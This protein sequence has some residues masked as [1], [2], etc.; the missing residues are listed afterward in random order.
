[1]YRWILTLCG[2]F[3]LGVVSPRSGLAG[4]NKEP[5][6]AKHQPTL[7]VQLGHSD[8]VTCLCLSRDNK[9]LITGSYDN[10]A[11]LWEV[12]TGTEIRAF[13]GHS[14]RVSCVS[15][16]HDGKWLVTGS[17]DNTARLWKVATG[18]E[19]R[20]FRGHSRDVSS[21]S[22]S[23]DGKWLVT[24]SWDKTARLWEV[25]TGK[26]VRAFKGHSGLVLS[27]SLSGDGKRLVTGGSD[28][29]A[30]L[31]DV[32][33]GK[34]VRGFEGHA[35]QVT[36]VCLSND[37]KWV[38]TGSEDKSA[39]LWEVATGKEIL[40]FDHSSEVRSVSMSADGTWL[41]TRDHTTANL[42]EVATRK[43]VRTFDSSLLSAVYLSADGKWLV[44]GTNDRSARLWEAA[45]GKEV[46]TFAG[47][48]ISVRSVTLSGDGKRLA[49]CVGDDTVCMWDAAAGNQVRAFRGHS[50]II[51][52]AALSHDGKW[53][54]T[55]SY[56]Q[57]AR[58]WEVA[59]AKEAQILKHPYWVFAV[60]LSGDGKWLVT[61]SYDNSARL[62]EAATGKEVRAF[63]G[64][65]DQVTS[66]C[67][68]RD[69]R[70]LVTGSQ[71]R[72]ARLW[73]VATG[74]EVRTFRGHA[75]KVTSVCLSGD[76]KSLLSASE[77][78]TARLWEVAT[79]KELRAFRDRSGFLRSVSLSGDGKWLVTSSYDKT[80]TLWN[81]TTGKE[82]RVF[83][84]HSAGISSVAIAPDGKQVLTGSEDCTTRFWDAAT[85][86]E[87]CRLVSF[88]NGTWAV[89]APDGRFDTND[90]DE[91]KGLHWLMPDD[92][93]TPLPVEIFQ[94]DYYEPRLLA[95]I[96]AGE[97]LE[98]IR[99]LATLNRVQPKIEIDKIEPQPGVPD[100]VMV[101]VTVTSQSRTLGK[102]DQKKTFH[103]GA[104]DLQLFRDGQ[105]VASFPDPDGAILLDPKTGSKTHRFEHVRLP[106]TAGRKE[107]EFSAY[108]FNGDRVKSLTVRVRHPLPVGLAA[109]PRTAY[110]VAIGINAFDDPRWDLRYAVPDARVLAQ[111]LERALVA[112]KQFKRV[113]VVPLVAD[114]RYEGGK[115]F[116]TDN[117]A[118]KATIQAVLRILAG[119]KADA[120]LLKHVPAAK[121][122]AAARPEDL[123]LISFSTHGHNGKDGRFHLLP[124]DM[125]KN[126][127]STDE[128]AHW[129]RDVDAGEMILIVDACHS[130]A[131]VDQKGFKPGP[132]GS[133]GLGQM[134]YS[135]RMRILAASQASDVA[136]EDARLGHGL[137]TFALLGDG[138][139]KGL[140]DFSP[141][142][143]RITVGEWLR[144]GVQR[145]PALVDDIAAGK[146]HAVSSQGRNL[147]LPR[148]KRG[149]TVI[150][151]D[152][153]RRKGL[154]QQPAL[155]DFT[156]GAYDVLLSQKA[157]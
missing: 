108:A 125:T 109:R 41:A 115:R 13:R 99:S 43:V 154:A 49:I 96:L 35:R 85:G 77:D 90:L 151:D 23:A 25:A 128:L 104:F 12:A 95:R 119:H 138:L 8:Y 150:D 92:P 105:L 106:R 152:V 132:M 2:L 126:T 102:A 110:V 149:L 51:T 129:L 93:F 52:C 124:S 63:R 120:G 30:C 60:A 10:T 157:R 9:W 37:D 15:L 59:R 75:D 62:W 47:H 117:S 101:T 141:K 156:R 134:A 40:V 6:A 53:L 27:V 145:V 72:T 100:K 130:A 1:M 32:A 5:V 45:T 70:W 48:A 54:A 86:Q 21:V 68:S 94:R 114:A 140:A 3:L 123:V 74:K 36:S 137:L 42:W 82:V 61:N 58:L 88:Q 83:R 39:R 71:D 133:R 116:I 97:K 4:D 122:L 19:I 139:K 33:T 148:G 143:N 146:L 112:Q 144:Y 81:A 56:D 28:A 131:T 69:G 46:C 55:G 64:H 78:K 113:V 50:K 107:V 136:F 84:G 31:W 98:P 91:I 44:A 34:E 67:L 142:D 18:E 111:T 20:V 153:K 11:R 87:L 89:I 76:G 22:L 147:V 155:F 16:S 38:V 127:M 80:A 29:T 66:A 7:V 26:E 121:A 103:S 65:S 14:S 57:T 118:S 135:K 17:L 79:G 24:G 73:D